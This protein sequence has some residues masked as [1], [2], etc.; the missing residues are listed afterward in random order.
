MLF[1][2]FVFL[3]ISK[4]IQQFLW[5]ILTG[6][7]LKRKNQRGTMA[8]RILKCDYTSDSCTVQSPNR[9]RGTGTADCRLMSSPSNCTSK[10]GRHW[11]ALG[12]GTFSKSA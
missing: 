3:V 9:R 2:F 8:E 6:T 11:S 1:L 4:T 5:L 12:R 10:V 7:E